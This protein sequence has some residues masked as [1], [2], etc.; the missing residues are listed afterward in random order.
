MVTLYFFSAVYTVK[1]F[2]TR[3]KVNR[4]IP[5]LLQKRG[6]RRRRRREFRGSV[7][8][9]SA[10][11]TGLKMSVKPELVYAEGVDP[12]SIRP[13]SYEKYYFERPV[14]EWIPAQKA[15]VLH[16]QG[17]H[18]C[19]SQPPIDIKSKAPF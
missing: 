14:K 17:D 9:A 8:P 19:C 13:G 7:E 11:A 12:E 3:R 18:S 1:V 2:N 16:M 6:L 10:A 4:Y 15:N 5:Q